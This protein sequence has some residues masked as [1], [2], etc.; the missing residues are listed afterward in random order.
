MRLFVKWVPNYVRFIVIIVKIRCS[1]NLK[2]NSVKILHSIAWY[3]RNILYYNIYVDLG[4]PGIASSLNET[5]LRILCNK[6]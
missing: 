3:Q 4:K 2:C 1:I 5:A 6:L